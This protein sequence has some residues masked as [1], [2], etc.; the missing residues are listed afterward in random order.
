MKPRGA[1]EIKRFQCQSAPADATLLEYDV[2]AANGSL[3]AEESYQA[4][5]RTS[6]KA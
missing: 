6:C 5:F 2:T 4:F 1:V 3:I